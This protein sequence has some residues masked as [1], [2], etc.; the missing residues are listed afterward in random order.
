M[1]RRIHKSSDVISKLHV[2]KWRIVG[3]HLKLCYF[4]ALWFWCAVVYACWWGGNKVFMC[5]GKSCLGGKAK[6]SKIAIS[7][8]DRYLAKI[9]RDL[10]SRKSPKSRFSIANSISISNTGAHH[11]LMTRQGA[12]TSTWRHNIGYT[13]SFAKSFFV[14]GGGSTREH[15]ICRAVS[16]HVLS[17]Q[18]LVFSRYNRQSFSRSADYPTYWVFSLVGKL[19][20]CVTSRLVATIHMW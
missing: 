18:L 1:T 9:K 5:C 4:E 11:R 12:Y 20:E 17:H 3:S 7:I 16:R 2:S 8:E 10:G 19:V 6:V 15:S 13:P 14:L